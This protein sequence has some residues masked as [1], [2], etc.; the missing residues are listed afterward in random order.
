MIDAVRTET[1]AE[2]V[3]GLLRTAGIRCMHRPTNQ[4]VGATDGAVWGLGSREVLVNGE[5]YEAAR[6]V[7]VAQSTE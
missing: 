4:A 6:E 3:C 7:L 1:E 2:L 5:D